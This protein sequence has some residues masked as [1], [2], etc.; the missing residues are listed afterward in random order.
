MCP[1]VQ[2]AWGRPVLDR[3]G[4]IIEI[5]GAHAQTRE[6]KLQVWFVAICISWFLWTYTSSSSTRLLS[7]L[8]RKVHLCPA[9]SGLFFPFPFHW[10]L[11]GFLF[12]RALQ[13]W[14]I[15]PGWLPL[16]GNLQI[17]RM[18][19]EEDTSWVPFKPSM[20]SHMWIGPW[21]SKLGYLRWFRT[22]FF[23]QL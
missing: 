17:F 4:L 15:Y 8:T 5:F 22:L 3:V 21:T 11:L 10:P 13:F 12:Q 19:N 1:F 14:P 18:F 23:E 7:Q 20:S 2:A 6:A 16:I 9:W